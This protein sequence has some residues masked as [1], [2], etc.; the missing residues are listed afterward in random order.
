M[1]AVLEV[2]EMAIPCGVQVHVTGA[3]RRL[4]LIYLCTSTGSSCRSL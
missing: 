2:R 4:R 3:R 1:K